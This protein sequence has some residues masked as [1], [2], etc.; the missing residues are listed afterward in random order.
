MKTIKIILQEIIDPPSH[1]PDYPPTV[2]VVEKVI[3]W[4]E[5]ER[6]ARSTMAEVFYLTVSDLEV[7]LE[8][9]KEALDL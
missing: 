4:D 8:K 9:E 7:R 1:V 2:I 5:Y 6:F 3:S